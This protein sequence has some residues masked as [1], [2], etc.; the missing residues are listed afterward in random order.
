[1]KL[2][3][4]ST[5]DIP[6][7]NDSGEYS[8]E[9]LEYLHN[10]YYNGWEIKSPE[11]RYELAS[12]FTESVANENNFYKNSIG[13]WEIRKSRP[14]REPD[15][16]SWN[17]YNFRNNGKMKPSSEYWYSS[18]GVIRGSDHWGSDV[19]SCSWYLIGQSYKRNYGVYT[20]NKTYAY[21]SWNALKAKGFIVR[22]HS[23]GEYFLSGFEFE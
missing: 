9:Y 11:A 18:D 3:I 4:R 12:L 10:L 16:T 6:T 14:R 13:F 21:I 17:Y 15:Y 20:G 7:Y 23:T 19:A 8:Q 2:Y 22:N 1:M 5:I